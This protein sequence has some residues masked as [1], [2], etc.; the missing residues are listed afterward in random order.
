MS[1][2]VCC[3]LHNFIAD[4][5]EAEF[6]DDDDGDEGYPAAPEPAGN[7]DPETSASLADNGG[8]DDDDG[9]TAAENR[10]WRDEI[11]Q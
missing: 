7:V 4:Q 6:D 3:L 2:M 9:G 5:E 8:D 11:A 1:I 10:A